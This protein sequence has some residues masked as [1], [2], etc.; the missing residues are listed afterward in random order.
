L[1]PAESIEITGQGLQVHDSLVRSRQQL[2]VLLAELSDHRA[3]IDL[4]VDLPAP[5]LGLRIP[6]TAAQHGRPPLPVDRD[7]HLRVGL[8]VVVRHAAGIHR[9]M[10]LAVSKIISTLTQLKARLPHILASSAPRGRAQGPGGRDR[11]WDSAMVT[12][13]PRTLLHPDIAP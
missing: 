7:E 4:D 2:D 10:M 12:G 6:R 8:R 11:S 3:T 1:G 13:S 5:R 9:S